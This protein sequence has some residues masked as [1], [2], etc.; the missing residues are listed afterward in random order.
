MYHGKSVSCLTIAE[1]WQ[2]TLLNEEAKEKLVLTGLI[3][4]NVRLE[5]MPLQDPPGFVSVKM[6]F[7]MAD[8]VIIWRKAGNGQ[9]AKVTSSMYSFARRVETGVRVYKLQ[10]PRGYFPERIIYVC[11]C[12]MLDSLQHVIDAEAPLI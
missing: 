2:I 3:V 1:T 8:N 5:V 7:E 6:L 9:V 4:N 10:N 11:M 12:D